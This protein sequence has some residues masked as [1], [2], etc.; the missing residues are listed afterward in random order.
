[1]NNRQHIEAGTIEL[2]PSVKQWI[3]NE[4]LTILLNIAGYMLLLADWCPAWLLALP[5]FISVH[6]MYQLV[7]LRSMRFTFTE[8]MLVRERGVFSKQRDY[9]EMYRMFDYHETISF[10][11]DM[12]GLKTVAIYSMDRTS[13]KLSVP[14]IDQTLQLV[15]AI[16]TRVERCKRRRSIYEI[17]NR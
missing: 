5:A 6:L 8:E 13:P 4:W 14:G 15:S 11:Q 2:R 16:R 3:C 12:F 10:I 7:Y 17:T 9:I 1:M